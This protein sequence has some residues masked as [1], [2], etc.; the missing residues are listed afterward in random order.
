MLRRLLGLT[1]DERNPHPRM[2]SFSLSSIRG[3]KG[4]TPEQPESFDLLNPTGKIPV[5]FQKTPDEVIPATEIVQKGS[6]SE[7]TFKRK[8][9]RNF[10][11]SGGSENSD[12]S[13]KSAKSAKSEKVAEK[14]RKKADKKASGPKLTAKAPKSKPESTPEPTVALTPTERV[15]AACLALIGPQIRT[16]LQ[17]SVP[18]ALLTIFALWSTTDQ[19]PLLLWGGLTLVAAIVL[20]FVSRFDP[21]LDVAGAIRGRRNEITAACGIF[22][23]SWGVGAVLTFGS[24]IDTQR[25]LLLLAATA[26]VLGSMT[27]ATQLCKSAAIALAAPAGLGV[28]GRFFLGSSFERATA[29]VALTIMVVHLLHYVDANTN[30]IT[31]VRNRL[32]NELLGR[33]L[34]NALE[35]RMLAETELARLTEDIHSDS[36]RDDIT[37]VKNRAAFRESLGDLWQRADA[38]FDP[39]SLVLLDIDQYDD[40]ANQHGQ[41]VA[42]DLLR[43]VAGMIDHALRTDDMVARLGNSQFGLLLNNALTDGALICMERIRRKVISTPFDAG[44]P[45]LVSI[46]IAVVTW[47]RG[48]GLRQIFSAADSTLQEA[49]SEGTNQ[50]KVWANPNN[51]HLQIPSAVGV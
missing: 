14:F 12:N 4:E 27:L 25:R 28:V 22:G 19:G 21:V 36:E 33:K 42:N 47:E 32:E 23:L 34:K 43:Q 3:K 17:T 45:L 38:G 40:I 41:D 5:S 51:A 7:K 15:E 10:G 18:V 31:L 50:L 39:F 1:S 49:K 2:S 24:I 16:M 30:Q 8:K 35:M 13:D 11:E 6:K 48:V 26:G 29:V 46:S 37:G 44:Q 9:L 20:A